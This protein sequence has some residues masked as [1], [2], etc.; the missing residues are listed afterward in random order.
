[1]I[2]RSA[3][4]FAV[5]WL[6]WALDAASA[7]T[8][9][10]ARPRPPGTLEVNATCGP[11][12]I[13]EPGRTADLAVFQKPKWLSELYLGVEECYDSNVYLSGV[14]RKDL[15]SSFSVPSGSA[16]ARKDRSSLVTTV[17]PRV[18]V[19]F[20]ALLP[21]VKAVQAF[22]IV[23]APAFGIYH[24]ESDESND[25]HRFLTKLEGREG[26]FSFDLDGALS[27][28]DGERMAPTYPGG[29]ENAAAATAPRERRRQLNSQGTVDLRY[30][31]GP[32]F[33]RPSAS[34]LFWDMRT[35]LLDVEGYQNYVDRYEIGGGAD[36][37]RRVTSQFA[38]TMGY[39]YGHQYQEKLRFH[40]LDSSNDFQRVLV[41]VEGKP[42]PWLELNLTFGPDFRDYGSRAAVRDKDRVTYY[43]H[44]TVTA[45]LSD[46]DR[47]SFNF[48]EWLWT[49]QLG[50]IPY[51]DSSYGLSYVHR[52][53]KGLEFET[54][55]VVHRYDYTLGDAPSSA[56]DDLE[57][58]ALAAVRYAFNSHAS[59]DLS[60]AFHRGCNLLDEVTH[61]STRSFERHLVMLRVELSM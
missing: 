60:Y 11:I 8:T 6:A 61:S 22:S 48:N 35:K 28:I 31:A 56:R 59:A 32:W 57:L 53:E 54:G 52:F 43:G 50:Q 41:G 12:K 30:D 33:V 16:I 29:L 36:V 37:G 25:A 2:A 20:T 40:S 39:R 51:F 5:L 49:S 3:I 58:I 21:G 19:D 47:V 46:S 27:F 23:Y 55:G 18:G 9:R 34:L 26:S 15:P 38:V 4:A 44:G 17:S 7:D 13:A 10:G 45:T 14:K 1:M 42:W 24:G